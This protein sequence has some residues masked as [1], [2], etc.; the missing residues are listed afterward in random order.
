MRK[1]RRL[2][3]VDLFFVAFQERTGILMLLGCEVVLRGRLSRELLEAGLV[4]TLARWPRLGQRLRKRIFGL[5]WSGPPDTD[6]ILREGSDTE[7]L[8][9]WRNR[10]IDPFRE[11]P[12]QLLWIAEG[13]RH[14]LSFRVHH[15]VADGES[16]FLVCR[17]LVQ[18][19]AA[20]TSTSTGP[21]PH[22]PLGFTSF[23][24]PFRVGAL[25]RLWAHGRWLASEARRP[26][27]ARL[28]LRSLEPGDVAVLTDSVGALELD[29]LRRLAADRRVATTALFAAAWMRA[30]HQ[31]SPSAAISLEVPV[32]LRRRPEQARW[33]GNYVAPLVVVGDARESLGDLA[34][35]IHRQLA[36][37]YRGRLHLATVL[38]TSF[39]RF[40]PWSVFRRLAVGTSS[41][42][43]ATGHFTAL[44]APVDLDVELREIS[45]GEMELM[46]LKLW[47]PVCRTM[48]AALA[49]LELPSGVEVFL[50]YRRNA[51][52]PGEARTLADLLRDELRNAASLDRRR[53]A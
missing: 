24:R 25:A 16:L 10:R 30:L 34:L 35:T 9:R 38:F 27:S 12:F 37:G 7:D 4:H 48:G 23:F 8:D 21:E 26:T 43:F 20:R 2:S 15:S 40:L 46:G 13:E 19:L 41:T 51:L 6:A 5:E 1:E 14:I 49:I 17:D 42:G 45:S 47:T 31:W 33:L 29:A 32:S 52:L 28:P 39:A 3:Q 44:R 11:P 50:T 18:F 53:L 36:Q 22:P